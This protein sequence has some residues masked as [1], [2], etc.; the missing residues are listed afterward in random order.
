M[1]EKY[2]ELE[3]DPSISSVIVTPKG[4]SFYFTFDKSALKDAFSL[5]D[6][7]TKNDIDENAK[8]VR[9]SVNF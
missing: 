7:V 6:A 1:K 8:I 2:P 5:T 9:I 3:I 4:Q